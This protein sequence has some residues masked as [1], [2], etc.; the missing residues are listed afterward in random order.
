MTH[1]STSIFQDAHPSQLFS[2]KYIGI[3]DFP[4]TSLL[5]QTP[6]SH[7]RLCILGSQ[8]EFCLPH[9][10][11]QINKTHCPLRRY[12]TQAS[13][14]PNNARATTT[15]ACLRTREKVKNNLK[16]TENLECPKGDI[17]KFHALE[18]WF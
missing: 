17:E 6:G 7:T 14:R 8:T 15:F 2:D 12:Q 9:L 3:G 1:P 13:N 11:P 16:N 18:V 5:H 4:E 10:F